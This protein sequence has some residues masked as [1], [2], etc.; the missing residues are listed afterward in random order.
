MNTEDIR[1]TLQEEKDK[2]KVVCLT[3]KDPEKPEDIY[4]F[5]AVVPRSLTDLQIRDEFHAFDLD[6]PPHCYQEIDNATA[7]EIKSVDEVQDTCQGNSEDWLESIPFM[8]R[9]F[10]IQD[11]WLDLCL[12]E[13]IVLIHEESSLEE[14]METFEENT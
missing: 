13:H 1:K 8:Y 7:Q 10:N 6:M 5:Y 14:I 12:E 2:A 11:N 3:I 9:P 4:K